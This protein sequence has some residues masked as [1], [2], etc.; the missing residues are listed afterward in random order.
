ME[1][2]VPTILKPTSRGNPDCRNTFVNTTC[3]RPYSTY[4]APAELAEEAEMTTSSAPSLLTST[5]PPTLNPTSPLPDTI[6]PALPATNRARSTG[7]RK[8][9]LERP[10]KI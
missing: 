3:E 9:E 5:P 10:N 2:D 8:L 1:T 6:K 7:G 4:T